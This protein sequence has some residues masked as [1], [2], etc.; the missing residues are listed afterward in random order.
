MW[1]RSWSGSARWRTGARILALAFSGGAVTVRSRGA[2]KNLEQT[3]WRD[4]EASRKQRRKQE[5]Q[6]S[7]AVE[8]LSLIHNRTTKK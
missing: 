5:S 4:R 2:R 1:R 6:E 3:A 7:S 8:S